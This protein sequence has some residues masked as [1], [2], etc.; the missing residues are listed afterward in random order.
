MSELTK[1]CS[2]VACL[3]N[4]LERIVE[5]PSTIE[6][7][8]KMLELSR[9][10]QA[11]I[12]EK[13]LP[14]AL[15]FETKRSYC[16]PVTGA[17]RFGPNQILKIESVNAEVRS[18]QNETKEKV[19][20]IHLYLD[21]HLK[22]LEAVKL[23]S[24]CQEILKDEISTQGSSLNVVEIDQTDEILHEKANRIR[25]KKAAERMERMQAVKKVNC[26]SLKYDVTANKFLSS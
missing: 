22:R 25:E 10:I 9:I 26:S 1:L 13:L 18:L 2:R 20:R 15:K 6:E 17:A 7:I 5:T 12:E 11:E 24:E 3:K 21:T 23:E 8:G 19:S 4:D 14:Q 16:D